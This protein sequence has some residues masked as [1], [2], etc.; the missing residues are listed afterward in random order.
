[1]VFLAGIQML[2]A[3]RLVTFYSSDS[4]EV[5]ADL[6]FKSKKYPFI[7]LTHGIASSR[8]ECKFIAERLTQLNYNCLAID[9][10]TGDE[11]NFVHN[12]TARKLQQRHPVSHID[13]K[14]DIDAAINY[15]YE[16]NHTPVILFGNT[17][18]ASLCLL[19]AKHNKKVKAVIGYTPGEYF[20]ELEIS[21]SLQAYDKPVFVGC[22]SHDKQYIDKL[23]S[24]VPQSLLFKSYHDAPLGIAGLDLLTEENPVHDP[25]WL[26][27]LFYFNNL[28]R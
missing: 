16:K 1:M 15:A 20:N 3:Q 13:A 21:E 19:S 25:Y 23:L 18:S 11:S 26:D 8:G 24:Q 10:R 14:K 6:Y 9:L 12:E 4:V 28:S 22:S 7:I 27:L 17:V 2:D 5:T